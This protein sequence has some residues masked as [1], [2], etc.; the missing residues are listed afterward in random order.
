MWGIKLIK[1]NRFGKNKNRDR[2]KYGLVVTLKEINGE[3][4]IDEFIQRCFLN[5]WFAEKVEIDNKVEVY[6][7]AEEEIK[8]E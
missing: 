3:N 6:N 4:R 2:I 5:Q 8:F 1:T 7:K